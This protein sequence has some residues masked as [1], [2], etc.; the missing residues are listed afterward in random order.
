[1]K[2]KVFILVMAILVLVG[3]GSTGSGI[4]KVKDTND[5][6]GTPIVK[7][8][9]VNATPKTMLSAQY[10][11]DTKGIEGITYSCEDNT[12]G[13]TSKDG[14]FTYAKDVSKVCMFWINNIPLTAVNTA[15]LLAGGIVDPSDNAKKILLSLDDDA[16]AS[17]GIKVLPEV[18]E[19]LNGKL[20]RVPDTDAELVTMVGYISGIAGYNGRAFTNTAIVVKIIGYKSD[21]KYLYGETVTLEANATEANVTKNS[22]ITYSWVVD[23]DTYDTFKIV[24][25]NLNEGAHDI[26]LTVTDTVNNT[27]AKDNVTITVSDYLVTVKP[28]KKVYKK[29]E[30]V[31][32]E[33]NVTGTVATLGYTWSDKHTKWKDDKFEGP[34][35]SDDNLSN[36]TTEKLTKVF[37]IGHHK[38]TVKV[39]ANN[40]DKSATFDFDVIDDSD[41]NRTL[42]TDKK[43]RVIV[44]K[45]L[46]WV[47]QPLDLNATDG[48]PKC[49]KIHGVSDTNK[50][51]NAE[52]FETGKKFCDLMVFFNGKDDWRTPTPTELKVF[53]D[54][55]LKQ[56]FL[57]VYDDKCARLLAITDTSHPDANNSY[58][59]VMSRYSS[60][61]AT[62]SNLTPNI[63]VRCV[64]TLP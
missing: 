7:L 45:N 64:R 16:N 30:N 23:N 36:F 48:K 18:V 57:S 27:T 2:I 49:A 28:T 39:S 41:F 59:T 26:N 31:T 50:T 25:N 34:A 8:P 60:S 9:D 44:H 35:L 46:M 24:I 40:S 38:V 4:S 47:D 15:N 51:L 29:D 62:D 3:C 54:N 43:D 56:N 58:A 61:P 10:L 1:M 20:K 21:K 6:N 53:I 22:N 32:L 42:S 12:T 33:A 52:Q 55:S 13:I 37:S 63:G 17:N 5:T 11:L 19:T 14:N